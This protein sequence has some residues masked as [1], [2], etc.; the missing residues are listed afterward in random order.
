MWFS[1]MHH[2]V[3]SVTPANPGRAGVDSRYANPSCMDN[4][5]LRELNTRTYDL[6]IPSRRDDIIYPLRRDLVSHL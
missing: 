4:K 2:P 5:T 6:S 3:A 1:L